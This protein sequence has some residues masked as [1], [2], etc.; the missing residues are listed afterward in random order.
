MEMYVKTMSSASIS[1]GFSS[2][3][4]YFRHTAA[5]IIC[6]LCGEHVPDAIS[7][8]KK[9]TIHNPR[10]ILPV[11]VNPHLQTRKNFTMCLSP[12]HSLFNDSL[13]LLEWIELNR[14]LGVQKFFLYVKS[15]SD[16]VNRVLKYYNDV[17]SNADV[18]VL[19]WS[20]PDI[21]CD[22]VML[23]YCGQLAALNDCLYR[24]KGH[25]FYTVS[26]DLDEFIIPYVQ[27]DYTWADM[28]LRIPDYSV[29]LFRNSFVMRDYDT[30]NSIKGSNSLM[31]DYSM[32][33]DFIYG[34][35][36]RS[37]MIARTDDV[38]TFGIHNVW[39]MQSGEEHGVDPN[40]GILHHYRNIPVVYPAGVNVTRIKNTATMKYSKELRKRIS[41]VIENMRN[42][43]KG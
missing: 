40:I 9:S 34:P 27:N 24:N 20:L 30:L 28:L 18:K 33:D 26:S 22:D 11:K 2:F 23:H 37:K 38:V 41:S 39:A 6:Y 32:R 8:V 31:T 42:A 4:Y 10:N 43:S 16:D 1:N 35:R 13:Q 19:P 29:H 7:I 21:L 12:I 5:Y 14:I 36:D 25:S 3:L 15:V 17:E